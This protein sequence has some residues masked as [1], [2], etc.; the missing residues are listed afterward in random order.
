MSHFD[1]VIVV[2]WASGKASG[3]TPKK[4]A[5]WIG[6]AQADVVEQPVY[7][8]SRIDAEAWL[9][10]RLKAERARGHRVLASFDFPFAYPSG[11]AKRLIGTEDPFALWAW[12]ADRIEDNQKG[13]NNRFDV[14]GEVNRSFG[15]NGPFWG[16]PLK[17][18]IDGLPRRKTVDIAL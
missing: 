15:G 17:R 9:L 18:D 4:D 11:F 13:E 12:F 2:D 5:I 10:E 6:V 1:T 16:N 8:R 3:P 7:M 14:A